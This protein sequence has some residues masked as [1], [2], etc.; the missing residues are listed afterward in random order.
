[1]QS[2]LVAS[3]SSQASLLAS[4]AVYPFHPNASSVVYTLDPVHLA[5]LPCPPLLCFWHQ[6]VA[7]SFSMM[8]SGASSTTCATFATSV[9]EGSIY[10]FIYLFIFIERSR[11]RTYRV[12]PSPQ[13]FHLHLAIEIAIPKPQ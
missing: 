4:G 3:V 11:Q 13:F 9:S 1:M 2:S 7:P 10:L 5:F 8:D 6:K 12:P